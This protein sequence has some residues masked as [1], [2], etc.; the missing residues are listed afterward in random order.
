M[1]NPGFSMFR[2][3]SCEPLSGCFWS[4]LWAF[5]ELSW[6]SLGA[7]LDSLGLSQVVFGLSWGSL[8]ALLGLWEFYWGSVGLSWALLVLSWALLV[9]LGPLWEAPGKRP[10]N[11]Y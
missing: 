5:F 2:F 7:L 8:G 10:S 4:P 6:G 3:R 9:G 1:E 11:N